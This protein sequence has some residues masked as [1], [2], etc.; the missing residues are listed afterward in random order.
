MAGDRNVWIPFPIF[1]E[2]K[3]GLG[4]Y[5][6]IIWQPWDGLVQGPSLGDLETGWNLDIRILKT[7]L[8]SSS[9]KLRI[10]VFWT[11]NEWRVET[12]GLLSCSI[13]KELEPQPA[14]STPTPPN[15]FLL[16]RQILKSEIRLGVVIH[17]W[18]PAIQ[19]AEAGGL[20]VQGHFGLSSEFLGSL[21]NLVRNCLKKKKK[22][23]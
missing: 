8:R 9:E 1:L 7:A 5:L 21:G 10:T 6:G 15:P 11:L 3:I 23:E 2:V 13:S 12:T 18:I 14:L 17:I 4:L 19:E 16:F 22:S 20:Q